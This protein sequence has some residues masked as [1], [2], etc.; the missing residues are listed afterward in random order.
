MS[1]LY[2]L[3]LSFVL[4]PAMLLTIAHANPIACMVPVENNV[5][6][7]Q[8]TDL[9][10][11]SPTEIIKYGSNELQF[12]E[13]WLAETHGAN[14][15]PPLVIFIHGGCW[16]NEYDVSHTHALSTALS[17]S[18][19]AVWAVEYRR[20]GDEGGG[21]PGS[22]ND[23]L[24]AIDYSSKLDAQLID[25]NKVALIGH[26]AGGHLALLAAKETKIKLSAVIGL[27]AIVDLEEYA[28]GSNSCEIATPKFM[29]GTPKQKP[30]DYQTANPA[31][32]PQHPNTVL[33]HGSEDTIVSVDQSEALNAP[34]KLVEGAGH[35][36]MIHPGTEAYRQLLQELANAFK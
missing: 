11:G 31:K 34:T 29:G 24:R 26:S 13:L 8:V 15:K 6:Y 14:P 22:Y 19:Y 18:G 36:D 33:I 23:T 21:W 17:H 12:G 30:K 27:A 25:L 1:K 35:F 7:S 5:S 10:T 4:L 3:I 20:T 28:L 16:L 9:I 2:T 32:Q